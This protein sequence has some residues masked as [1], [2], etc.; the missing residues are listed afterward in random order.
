[1]RV[2]VVAVGTELL[3]GQ[4]VDTN[5]VWLGETLSAVGM[6]RHYTTAVGDNLGRIVPTPCAACGVASDAVI[7]CGG[8]GPHHDDVTRRRD[9]GRECASI[10]VRTTCV[11]DV[12]RELFAYD[13]VEGS[14]PWT[15]TCARRSCSSA[16]VIPETRGTAPD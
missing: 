16:M 13:V 4:I 9:R 6:D 14:T 8:P 11:A 1:M 7:L 2:E 15:T 12:I 3:L 5:A 10:P